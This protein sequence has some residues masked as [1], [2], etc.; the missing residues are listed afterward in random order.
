ML[1]EITA[2]TV[3]PLSRAWPTAQ[4]SASSEC[5]DPSTP[6]TMRP[7]PV[8]GWSVPGVLMA[9][10]FLIS[11]GADQAGQRAFGDGSVLDGADGRLRVRA[12]QDVR[13]LAQC[14]HRE[15]VVVR[16]ARRAGRRPAAIARAVERLHGARRRRAGG[17]L[18]LGR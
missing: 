2:S 11:A 1:Q 6:T 14:V 5:A 4:H 9:S 10:L 16:A 17:Q 8:R 13:R 15:A 18:L 7:E 12:V 3:P